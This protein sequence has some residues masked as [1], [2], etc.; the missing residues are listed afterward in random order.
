MVVSL[1]GIVSS[2][3]A[4]SWS[5][6]IWWFK[7]VRNGVKGFMCVIPGCA[8][9]W[10][11]F[12]NFPWLCKVFLWTSLHFASQFRN[13]KAISKLGGDFVA[14][15][16]LGDHFI[17]ISQLKS[18]FVALKWVYGAAKRHWCAKKWF[19]SREIPCEMELW[20]WNWEFLCFAAISQLQ[21]TLRNGALAVKLGVFM[22]RSCKTPC[23]MGLWLRNWEFFMLRSRFT[24]AK[25]GSLCCEMALVCQK[26]ASQLRNPLRNGAFPVKMGSFML[27]WF[28]VV[29][30]LRND[31]H[32]VAKW[33]SCAKSGFAAAKIFAERGLR[34]WIGFAAKCWFR[35]GYEISLEFGSGRGQVE[36]LHH[37]I[38]W[39]ILDLCRISRYMY[40]SS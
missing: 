39:N 3:G 2:A 6:G 38:Q 26:V 20:L 27:W 9:L 10:W 21:N 31:G 28:A 14:I 34:L 1:D 17:T 32:Y 23:E 35:R 40:Q 5:Y 8:G 18:D 33:H 13:L 12:S 22:L 25:W 19:R 36:S 4:L 7:E 15:L 30:Q 29:S 24:A 37:M 11:H 16:K